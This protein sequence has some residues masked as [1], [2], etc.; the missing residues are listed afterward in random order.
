MNLVVTLAYHLKKPPSEL[1]E[2][3]NDGTANGKKGCKNKRQQEK[4]EYQIFYVTYS[5]KNVR[6]PYYKIKTC[7]QIVII[8]IVII[9]Q[10]A[11]ES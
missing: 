4:L 10:A 8:Q 11:S 5:T 2:K 7:I 6:N 1:N 9:K 3:S